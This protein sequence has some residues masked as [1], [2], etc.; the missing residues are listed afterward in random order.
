[1]L[2][3]KRIKIR[4]YEIGLYFRDG[5][6]KGLLGEGRHWLFDLFGKVRVDVA[7]M[8]DAWLAHDKLDMIFKSGALK[9]CAVVMD[10]KRDWPIA[11]STCCNP[12][13]PGSSN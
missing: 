2:F 3:F 10:L 8:R 4:S 13:A 7:N 9:D 12:A 5:E 6:F 11:W 1:M